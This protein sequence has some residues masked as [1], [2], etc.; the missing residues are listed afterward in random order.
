M[1]VTTTTSPRHRKTRR[2]KAKR[3]KATPPRHRK[4]RRAKAKRRKAKVR[5]RTPATTKRA[6]LRTSRIRNHECSRHGGARR[7]GWSARIGKPCFVSFWASFFLFGW[8]SVVEPTVQW[9]D[10]LHENKGAG[11]LH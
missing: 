5:R 10:A 1:T 11:W 6:R 8:F 9:L 3:R 2:A 7:L 4:T